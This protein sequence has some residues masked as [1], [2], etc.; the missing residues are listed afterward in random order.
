MSGGEIFFTI[1]TKSYLLHKVIAGVHFL[2]LPFSADKTKTTKTKK[3]EGKDRKTSFLAATT[4]FRFRQ[5][6]KCWIKVRD[7]KLTG[8]RNQLTGGREKGIASF[9]KRVLFAVPFTSAKCCQW[10]FGD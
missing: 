9:F 2:S 7:N 8:G 6:T 10:L 4:Q 5:G 3:K 1:I